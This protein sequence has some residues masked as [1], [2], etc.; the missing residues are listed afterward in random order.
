MRRAGRTRNS[1]AVGRCLSCLG[2]L[3]G[4]LLT[5]LLLVGAFGLPRW[6]VSGLFADLEA[7]GIFLEVDQTGYRPG[8]GIV[9]KSVNLYT[10]RDRVSPLI[11]AE[12][13]YVRVG[14]RRWLRQRVW[15][16]KFTFSG[17]SLETE[18]GLWADDLVT[19]QMLRVGAL[20]GHI[21]VNPREVEIRELEG[22]L[23]DLALKVSGRVP[24]GGGGGD[25]DWFPGAMRT[26]A[27]VVE[28][29]E[30]F[31]FTPFAEVAVTLEPR[32]DPE[33][34]VRAE[35]RVSFE[36]S[37]SHRGFP[38]TR[39]EAEAVYEDRV[40]RV[41]E[42]RLTGTGTEALTAEAVIDFRSEAVW[43]RLRNTLPRYAVEHLSPVPLSELL[44]RISVRVEGKADVDL[45]FGPSAFD[46]VGDRMSGQMHV[47]EAFYRDAFFP[48]LEVALNYAERTL[49]LENVRGEVGIAG[50]RGPVS[51][52]FRV[53]LDTDAFRLSAQTGFKPRAVLSLIPVEDVK[54][55]ISEWTFTDAP[56][57]MSVF[58]AREGGAESLE[59]E[60]SLRGEGVLCRGVALD[61]VILD[62]RGQGRVLQVKK[63]EARRDALRAAG[64][65]TWDFAGRRVDF[66][67]ESTLPPGD[68]AVLID[69]ALGNWLVPYRIRGR[70][71]LEASGTVDLSG[72]A[73]H[74][75]KA[76]AELEDVRWGWRR[77]EGLRFGVNLRERSLEVRDIW[78]SVGEGGF[79]GHVLVENLFRP[80]AFFA[81][82]LKGEGMDLSQM[83]VA[84]TDTE[85]TP[86]TGRLGFEVDLTGALADTPEQPRAGTF[87]G[88]GSVAVRDGELFRIPLLLGLSRILNRMFRE[89]G[90]AAQTDFTASFEVKEGRVRSEDLF[91]SGRMLSIAGEGWVDFDKQ[92][93]ANM[94]V[95]AFRRGTL[96]EAV[97]LVLWPLRKL[98][99]VRLTG[100]L[101]QPEWELRN[102]P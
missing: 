26:L 21:R 33:R 35:A 42:A 22:R 3:V 16:A 27:E 36:G 90:Y 95:Q 31:E 67:L 54:E 61:E 30:E 55:L 53:N 7:Q 66:V 18:L 98:I 62:L 43:F 23:G 50:E 40:L 49:Q 102:L 11:R 5:G 64:R 86:Y 69:P 9:L 25:M 44:E 94:R 6:A 96:A 8:R 63:L 24:V 12:R 4:G 48:E 101:D 47:T 59:L 71:R 13:M 41:P 2:L 32:A 81:L 20:R 82:S 45:E 100:T 34:G 83:I 72:A 1:S 87:A 89:I 58:V 28:R 37:G 99:E 75:V 51:G 76:L 46:R 79:G 65:M 80:D 17:G 88:M 70:S 93:R 14:W 52:A 73:G 39:V 15:S 38:V 77:F 78:G 19:R 60:V 74:A 91:L 85:Q 97:N 10:A 57:Q 84:A 68:V 56:P 29:V 92:V